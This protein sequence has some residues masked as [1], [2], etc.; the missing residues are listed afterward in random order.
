M[1][2]VRRTILRWQEHILMKNL[3]Y[4]E[5]F[6]RPFSISFTS[7]S[8]SEKG[9]KREIKCP[10]K[11]YAVSFLAMDLVLDSFLPFFMT[12]WTESL[13]P[14]QLRLYTHKQDSLVP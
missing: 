2:S 6:F 10:E 12:W 1:I 14:K 13:A 3:F 8:F 4:K 5:I 11:W 7:N 9:F